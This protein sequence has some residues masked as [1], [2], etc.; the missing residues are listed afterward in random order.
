MVTSISATEL[1]GIAAIDDPV[2]RNRWITQT[3]HQIALALQEALGTGNGTW[4]AFGV[5]ALTDTAPVP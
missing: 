4:C 2:R 3:Y 5:W 1:E